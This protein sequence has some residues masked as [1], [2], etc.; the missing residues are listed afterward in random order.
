MLKIDG[1]AVRLGNFELS[2][3]SFNVGK[4]DY[5]IL[6][7]ESG[8]G[9]TVMLELIAG[10]IEPDQGKIFLDTFD[11]SNVPIQKR[12][13]GL[14][15]QDHALFP[16]MTV[17]QNIGY[18]LPDKQKSQVEELA[19]Q[20]GAESLLDRWPAT[21]SPGESQ[22]VALA[23]TLARRPK[24]LMLDEPLASLDTPSKAGIRSLL[25]H[26]NA[27]GQTI[28][29]VTHD[30]EEAVA[31]ANRVAVIEKGRVVQV[32]TPEDVFHSPRYQ[33]VASFVGIKNFFRGKTEIQGD[34]HF[35]HA[36]QAVFAVSPCVIGSGS[37]IFAS[38]AVTLSPDKPHG[39]ARNSFPGTVAEIE[40]VPN[41]FEVS[42]DIGVRIFSLI[43]RV[44]F[45]EM[46]LATGKKVWASFKASAIRF[47][48]DGE[49]S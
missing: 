44:S 43:S 26:I 38:E 36:G 6:L 13:L 18:S 32:G 10:L 39:S 12:D 2:A 1:L 3:A 27:A 14:V 37:I 42:V 30:F 8:A 17:R 29:H 45:E 22:R 46:G 9:K 40:P 15:Y 28:I 34:S 19:G 48:P 33:F 7:G 47:I 31:L 21:L 23:R 20:V 4:G 16:H 25:R 49:T 35:F 24:V 5:F 11:L 41:G